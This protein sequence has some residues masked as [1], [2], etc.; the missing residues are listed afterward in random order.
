MMHS[1]IL[2]DLSIRYRKRPQQIYCHSQNNG[3]GEQKRA[4]RSFTVWEDSGKRIN[5]YCQACGKTGLTK[6]LHHVTNHDP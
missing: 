3:L 1:K 2:G 5:T 6:A 4:G